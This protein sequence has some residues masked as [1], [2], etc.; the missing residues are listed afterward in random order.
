MEDMKLLDLRKDKNVKEILD[1]F[2]LIIIKELEKSNLP[3]F[4]QVG[5]Q[6]GIRTIDSGNVGNG[7][8]LDATRG[9]GELFSNYVKGLGFEGLV[10]FE[11][12]EPPNVTN[13][14]SYVIFDPTKVKINKENKI[15]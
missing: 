8:L 10:T 3:W 2:K 5:L 15:S 6:N 12:G 1:G 9:L 13:H 11:G 4:Y 7:N 14:D